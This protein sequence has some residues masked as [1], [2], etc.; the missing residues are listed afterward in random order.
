MYIKIYHHVTYN[1]YLHYHSIV[2]YEINIKTD[3]NCLMNV[4]LTPA[5]ASSLLFS[6]LRMTENVSD[7]K[8]LIPRW[9]FVL[10]SISFLI[11]LIA[12][13]L[14]V[15]KFNFELSRHHEI[16]GQF[17]DYLGGIL[18]PLFA[19]T[20]LLALLYT[21]VLQ[22]K[23]LRYSSKQLAKSAGALEKQNTVLKKQSF[24]AT[25]FQLLKLYNDVVKELHITRNEIDQTSGISV[26]VKI[27]Y[28]D[29]HCLARLHKQ[30][31]EEYLRTVT[32]GDSTL[33]RMEALAG[34]Y[35]S[36]YAR[37]GHMIGHY[38]RT[39]Y[40]IVKIVNLS[41]LSDTEKRTY[42]NIL[43]AQLSKHELGLLLYNCLSK[44]GSEKMLPL[45][46]KYNLLKHL[47]DDVLSS[48]D[49]KLLVMGNK[50]GVT[51]R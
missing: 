8:P 39:I 49:D 40:N 20:A 28:E 50:L 3:G 36:F 14:Y 18:N 23:E 34:A 30:L 31:I 2:V 1:I 51:F 17:G 48:P 26:A 29:R 47:E 12:I 37:Y 19:F 16:W 22:S 21:I 38:F 33:P 9:L 45:V 25:F 13:G 41:D 7:S 35:C 42:T 4:G 24:E 15:W 44:Y 46:K 6:E 32:R 11:A 10:V 27:D 5:Y 43:R